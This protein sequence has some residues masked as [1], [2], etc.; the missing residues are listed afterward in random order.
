MLRAALVDSGGV[1]EEI[2]LG[3]EHLVENAQRQSLLGLLPM[4]LFD[5]FANVVRF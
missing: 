3:H 2:Q 5:N 4:L 1:A